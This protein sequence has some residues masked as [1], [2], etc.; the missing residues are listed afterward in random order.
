MCTQ[1]AEQKNLPCK[2]PVAMR[3]GGGG[4]GL[5]RL[6]R[7]GGVTLSGLSQ[8]VL[9]CALASLCLHA[10]LSGRCPGVDQAMPD[11]GTLGCFFQFPGVL[12]DSTAFEGDLQVVLY[13]L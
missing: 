5:S 7:R 10:V 2:E 13:I 3:V 11:G 12:V 9:L 8:L 1:V 6:A 4:G